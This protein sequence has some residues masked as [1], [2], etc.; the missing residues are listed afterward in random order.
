MKISIK[1]QIGKTT[2]VFEIDEKDEMEAM[3]KAGVLAMMPDK[4]G[5]CGKDNVS[6][7]SNKAKGYTFVKVVCK[8]CDAQAQLGQYKEGGY[9]WKSWIKYKSSQQPE[10]KEKEISPDGKDSPPDYEF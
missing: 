1:K 8:E 2:F 9:F 10:Q 6:L 7:S 4:C 3:S 5:L